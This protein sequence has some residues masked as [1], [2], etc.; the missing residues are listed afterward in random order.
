[1]DD[2]LVLSQEERA[3]LK[4]CIQLYLVDLRR[5]TA[6]TEAHVMQHALAQRQERLEAILRRL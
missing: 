1:M 2:S 5:E 4:E 3:A 6:A